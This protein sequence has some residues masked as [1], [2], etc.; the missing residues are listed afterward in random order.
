MGRRWG[1]VQAASR[2]RRRQKP[3]RRTR[4]SGLSLAVAIR[5][6]HNKDMRMDEPCLE[7]DTL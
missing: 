3:P 7:L 4:N 6:D 5:A 1:G 2:S